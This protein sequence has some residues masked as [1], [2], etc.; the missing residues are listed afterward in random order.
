M[1]LSLGFL[2]LGLLSSA[3]E[4]WLAFRGLRVFAEFVRCF[5]TMTPRRL[6]WCLTFCRHMPVLEA[7]KTLGALA[8]AGVAVV[9]TA[10]VVVT[11]AALDSKGD[12]TPARIVGAAGG[13]AGRSTIVG[14]P[15][16]KIC[17]Q[18]D[19]QVH[20]RGKVGSVLS[21]FAFFRMAR[22]RH[23]LA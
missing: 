4:S 18:P 22:H 11:P 8:G 16:L 19:G 12:C 13:R 21:A 3:E 23:A 1:E 17:V 14:S 15:S 6:R 9:S 5:A 2:L 10:L 7:F 20:Y